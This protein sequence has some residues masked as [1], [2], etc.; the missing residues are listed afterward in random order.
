MVWASSHVIVMA[1]TKGWRVLL[2]K[3]K[4]ARIWSGIRCQS[5]AEKFVFNTDCTYVS[6]LWAVLRVSESLDLELGCCTLKSLLLDPTE[7][8]V[9]KG[10]SLQRHCHASTQCS[11]VSNEGTCCFLPLV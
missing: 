4:Q 6:G 7:W 2:F 10:L 5:R 8:V 9:Q 3:A 1:G 11:P